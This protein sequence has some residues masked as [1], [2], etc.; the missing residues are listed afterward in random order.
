MD[1][2][3]LSR[4]SLSLE[5]SKNDSYIYTFIGFA[6]RTER[7]WHLTMKWTLIVLFCV[8]LKQPVLT[9]DRREQKKIN[10]RIKYLENL[11]TEHK[12]KC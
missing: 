9:R 5:N 12:I 11:V 7:S 8:I 3:C 1:L 2:I 6:P 10:S 4:I